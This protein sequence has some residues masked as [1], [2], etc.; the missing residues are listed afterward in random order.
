MQLDLL[1]LSLTV[2]TYSPAIEMSRKVAEDVNPH[3]LNDNNCDTFVDIHG[4][5]VCDISKLATAITNVNYDIKN[6]VYHSDK[7][8]FNDNEGKTITIILYSQIGTKQFQKFHA[9]L[10]TFATTTPFDYILRH[11]YKR[12]N[13]LNPQSQVEHQKWEQIALSGYGVELD[14][15]ST[16]YKAK[17]DKNINADESEQKK[18]QQ[19]KEDEERDDNL[20]VQGFKFNKLKKNHPEV[21]DEL[22]EFRKHLEDMELELAPLKPW[23]MQDLSI[24]AAQLIL[25]APDQSEHLNIL[26][27]LA[28][29]YPIRAQMLS[30]VPVKVD[31]RKALKKQKTQIEKELQLQDTAANLY[32]NGLDLNV[33]NCDI[34]T[35]HAVLR[36]EAQLVE[37]LH[38]AGLQMSQ[39]NDLVYLDTSVSNDDNYGVDI[40]DTSIQW[41]ND[42]E[43][44]SDN[45]YAY[46]ARNVEDILRPTYPGMM[47]SIAKNF[48]NMIFIVDAASEESKMLLK[49]AESFYVNDV[50]IRIGFVFVTTNQKEVDGFK[51]ASVALYRA[52]NYIKVTLNSAAKALSFITDVY[53]KAGDNQDVSADIIV[54][55][56]KKKFPKEKDLDDIFGIESDYDEGRLLSMEYY[57][58][59]GLKHLPQVLINGYPLTP[60]ELEAEA[61]EESVITKVMY[62]TSDIQMAVHKGQLTNSMPLLDWL[63]KKETIMARLN[64]RILS[65]ER[66]FLQ[67]NNFKKDDL[68]FIDNIRYMTPASGGGGG[69]NDIN[70]ITLWIVGDPDTE[71]GRKLIYDSI[72]FGE[73]SKAPTRLAFLFTQTQK[74]DIIKKAISFGLRTFTGKN[75][76]NF[77]KKI[78]RQNTWSDLI[79]NKKMLSQLDFKLDQPSLLDDIDTKVNNEDIKETIKS[80]IA[81]LKR[82]TPIVSNDDTTKSGVI[83]NGW[84]IG[85]FDKDESFIDTD[86]TLMESFLMKNGLNK[87]KDLV[88]KWKKVDQHFLPKEVKIDDILLKITSIIGRHS[89]KDK[90]TTRPNFTSHIVNIEPKQ[91]DIPFYDVVAILD[92]LTRDA[93]KLSTI[94]KVLTKITNMRL[95]IYLN[96]R[97]R[98]SAAPLKT[99]FRYVLDAGLQFIDNDDPQSLI[100]HSRAHFANMPQSSI[101]TLNI[102]APENWMVEAVRSPYDLDNIILKEADDQIVYGEYELEHLIIEGHSFDIKSGQPPRGLQFN[103]GT[104]KDP[105]L[106]D[107]IVMANLGY[108]Q[109]KASPGSWILQLREGLFH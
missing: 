82:N 44:R 98:L 108:F 9:A 19:K 60:A 42:L 3:Q 73:F 11:N 7:H 90:R 31:T 62:L 53:A 46:W 28:Q 54:K 83:A 89:S 41:L 12:F 39:I 74:D 85:P 94:L 91:K 25:D 45:K 8:F 49:T 52:Y 33:E 13:Q 67:V 2:R 21:S 106:Y 65:T 37:S 50:P 72:E 10:L 107:T 38:Q 75:Q 84:I 66:T 69:D 95:R 104:Q 43:S 105:F 34:F 101:L 30:K 14:I 4:E 71:I 99:F 20:S 109:L 40:R 93:Q 6:F 35:I 27:D 32:I 23:Q 22:K 86:F 81:F 87:I 36:K 1:K 29:N 17:D 56:F 80:H 24:Q 79:Q 100:E 26:E 78:L 63:M 55:A 15:K 57:N 48:F 97:D 88:L 47:R 59:I 102:L 5:I 51:D 96:C 61:F 68:D 16:E 103:L 70:F 18:V 58:K 64:M 92:P 76:L 77:I